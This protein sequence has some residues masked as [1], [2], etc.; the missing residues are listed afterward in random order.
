[1]RILFVCEGFSRHSINA[2]PWK[3]VFEVARRM[4]TKGDEVCVLT[5][6]NA[7]FPRN[8]VID[9]VQVRRIRKGKFLFDV[10]ELNKGLNGDFDV[11]N[12]NASGALSAL[13]FLRM[14]KFEENLV[15]TLHSGIIGLADIRNLKLTE[16]LSLGGFWNNIL[17]SMKSDVFVRRA[18]SLPNLKIIVALSKRLKDYFLSLGVNKERIRVI[19]SGVDVQIFASRDQKH[20]EESRE[21]MDFHKDEPIILYYGPL[22]SF[23]GV[24][25]LVSAM[26]IVLSKF[27]F[28]K[29]VFLARTL[30][31]D[32][33]SNALRQ[34]IME[35]ERAVLVEG[36]QSQESLIQYLNIADVVVLPF[37][38]WPYVEC[39]LTILETMAVGK[40]LVTTSTGAIPEIVQDK[41]TGLL[42]KP[43]GEE[44]GSATI[45]LLQSEQLASRLA[46]NARKY[47]E[48]YH[49]WDYVAEQT[50]EAFMGCLA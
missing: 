42:V 5:D 23:R 15:W 1:M 37:K 8:E 7:Y 16:I 6:L 26:P 47:V 49:S 19:Y 11:V 13:H 31:G 28:S 18:A 29:F 24:D 12:W 4:Q 2:Q 34:C 22:S 20:V 17:Y 40:P 35:H 14:K 10:D 25:E 45:E 48:K 21:N 38:F 27:P 9:G 46:Q 33:R 3:H 30:K 39:P 41:V 32:P 44:I 36:V 43:S 50:R